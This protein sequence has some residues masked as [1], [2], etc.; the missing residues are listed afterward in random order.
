MS[1]W[2]FALSV[3]AL[4]VTPGP[5]NTLLA[6]AG[7]GQ[8]VRRSLPLLVAELCAYLLT[9]STL[10]LLLGATLAR[11]PELMAVSRVLAA[12]WVLFLAVKLWGA[13]L[14]PVGGDGGVSARR[15]FVTTLLNPKGL[16]I[17]TVLL[18]QLG[19]PEVFPWLGLFAVLVVLIALVWLTVG[20]VVLRRLGAYAP[21]L[22]PRMAAL[23]LA[24]FSTLLLLSALQR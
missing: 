23:T 14:F 3:V 5:T 2:A 11:S 13:P 22:V 4:L 21:R 20:A 10:T 9:V 15:V 19:W 16:I 17:G 8:G 12:A 6:L 1:W 24:L 7:A 18:P